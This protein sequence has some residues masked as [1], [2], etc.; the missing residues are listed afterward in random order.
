MNVEQE[1]KKYGRAD[2]AVPREEKITEAVEKSK[3]AFY[4][5]EQE[6]E[7]PYQEFLWMQ[8]KFIKKRWWG[9]Q[10][11]LLAG[12]WYLLVLTEGA[13]RTKKEMGVVSV[14]FI[15]L[16]IPE[17]WRNRNS[18]SLEIEGAAYYSLRQIYA[19][20][21]MLFA[22]VDALLLSIFCGAVSVVL[23]L[24]ATELMIQFLLP[25]SVTASICFHVLCSKWHMSEA[26]AI[27]F[28]LFWS[29]VWTLILMDEAVYAAF[30]PQ[31]WLAFLGISVIYL[32]AGVYRTLN[33]CNKYWEENHVWN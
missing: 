7:L 3:K 5:K 19:A 9:F 14:L 4:A 2:R 26:V 15:V 29:A 11:L 17:L 16:V 30:A 12:F 1:L 6:G 25:M 8:F 31:V 22:A 20:R 21:M 10:L 23:R 18:Q 28:C 32:C 24:P 13:V 27:G 33:S